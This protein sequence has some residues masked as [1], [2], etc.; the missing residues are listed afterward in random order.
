MRD[1]LIYLCPVEF[2]GNKIS[3]E[4]DSVLMK[5]TESRIHRKVV[6]E[7]VSWSHPTNRR[8]KDTTR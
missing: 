4:K 5:Y 7:W 1:K 8:N 2:M 3:V 6:T